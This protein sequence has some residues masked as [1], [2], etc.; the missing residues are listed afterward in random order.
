MGE[1]IAK[2]VLIVGWGGGDW[3]VCE[4]LLEQGLMPN[5]QRLV[6]A[7]ATGVMSS[8]APLLPPVAWTSVATGKRPFKHGVHGLFEADEDIGG[9]RP[10]S[11][12]S[13]TT[14]AVWNILTQA[15][16]KTHVI[17]WPG[18]HPAEAIAGVNVT[19]QHMVSRVDYGKPWPQPDRS[20]HPSNLRK[21]VASIRLHP[22]EIDRDVLSFF[23]PAFE[24]VTLVERERL[25]ACTKWL[26]ASITN[27]AI[28]TWA[29]EH[30]PWDFMA[31]CYPSIEHLSHHYLQFV[32]PRNKSVSEREFELFHNV[33][34][35]CYQF[36][37][38]ML[39][40]LLQLA[41]RG[42]AVILMSPYGCKSDAG[43]AARPQDVSE[44][45]ESRCRPRGLIVMRGEHIQ[46]GSTVERCSVLDVTPTV[47]ALF[48]LPAGSDM[49]GRPLHQMV[50]SAR[51]ADNIES[52][53]LVNG[54]CGSH[55]P[56]NED[57][58]RR[59][60]TIITQ[61]A[62]M[63][64]RDPQEEALAAEQDRT[65]KRNKFNLA[66]SLMEGGRVA[67]AIEILNELKDSPRPFPPALAML[68]EAY[69]AAGANDAAHAVVERLRDI[70]GNAIVE[71][72]LGRIAIGRG[73]LQAAV[74]HLCSA[75][76][77][78]PNDA[79]VWQFLGR[80]YLLLGKG[81]D[82]RRAFEHAVALDP[83]NDDARD[84]LQRF[85]TRA[86]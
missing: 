58:R 81:V 28:A 41:G 54:V 32:P 80:T 21:S 44:D 3:N 14:T 39:G 65:V 76:K 57:S 20:V 69:L 64:Y 51:A 15:R 63:G 55:T 59:L 35:A 31:L 82:A 86:D 10:V 1:R 26:A 13:R 6:K 53:D 62:A 18:A 66:R 60:Q 40:R 85:N 2:R 30:R 8:V 16:F 37:D 61:L 79:R 42:T 48:G 12:E 11:S 68:I 71:L 5:L 36:H 74:K 19:D 67:Q 49:D 34:P 9:V 70:G 52:W 50:G 72:S 75:K 47:L 45:V 56:R 43:R 46:P 23:V 84:S 83:D 24:S 7:G 33:V 27:H 25:K 4:P 73:D 17:G 78:S 22:G 77:F 38:M 29:M